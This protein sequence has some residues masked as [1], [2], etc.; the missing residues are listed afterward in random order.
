MRSSVKKW[1]ELKEPAHLELEGG[2]V[3]LYLRGHLTHEIP[4]AEVLPLHDS[5][6]PYRCYALHAPPSRDITGD[7]DHYAVCLSSTAD[8]EAFLQSLSRPIEPPSPPQSLILLRSLSDELVLHIFSFLT[9]A[10]LLRAAQVCVQ[11]NIL[12]SDHALW[13]RAYVRAFASSKLEPGLRWKEQFLRH[14]HW[15]RRT[16]GAT[17]GAE[18][19]TRII[20]LVAV[21]DSVGS[22][23]TALLMAYAH[24]QF[25]DDYVPTVFEKCVNHGSSDHSLA[26]HSNVVSLQVGDFNVELQYDYPSFYAMFLR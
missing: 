15:R 4:I 11:W 18:R 16:P 7:E 25:P 10:D 21:G 14:A 6:R 1:G 22:E 24:D 8:G 9:P 13:R 20:K 23:K 26:A 19:P 12:S 2:I 3:K 5:D 17:D